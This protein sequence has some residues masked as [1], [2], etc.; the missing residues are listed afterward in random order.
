MYPSH[1]DYLQCIG[2]PFLSCCNGYHGWLKSLRLTERYSALYTY[3][4]TGFPTL[5]YWSISCFSFNIWRFC[6]QG[7][8]FE[9]QVYSKFLSGYVISNRMKIQAQQCVNR[10]NLSCMTFFFALVQVPKCHAVFRVLCLHVYITHGYC[11]SSAVRV[12]L[13]HSAS[14]VNKGILNMLLI[15]NLGKFL[16]VLSFPGCL[17]FSFPYT[18]RGKQF[19]P[20]L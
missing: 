2:W 14:V 15:Q 10:L 18:K 12:F 7:E 20:G 19:F 9:R 17:C 4:N 5:D 16:C 3:W 8:A 13:S 11:S 6:N 1:F